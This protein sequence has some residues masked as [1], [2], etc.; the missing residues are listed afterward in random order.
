M[1]VHAC[2]DD[3]RDDALHKMPHDWWDDDGP[4]IIITVGKHELH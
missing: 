3:D 4:V 2:M 1:Q